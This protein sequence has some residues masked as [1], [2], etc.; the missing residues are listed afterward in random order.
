MERARIAK[1]Q[2]P[3]AL[4]R[5]VAKEDILPSATPVPLH[6]LHAMLLAFPVAL[7]PGALLSDITY[8]NS[9]EMQWSNF[10]AWLITG[11]LLV[12]ALALLWALV[13]ALRR[14]GGWIYPAL[15]AA[16][17]IAGLINAFQHSHDAWSSVGTMGLTLSIVS[18]VLALLAGWT[19][20]STLRAGSRA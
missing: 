13:S 3:A 7:F 4:P 12:G 1:T 11:A 18:S 2:T 10:S 20:Y 9:A 17:W 16:M 15:L 6:P 19:G 14:R 5:R 8:L